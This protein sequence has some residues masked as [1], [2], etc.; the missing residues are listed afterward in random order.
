MTPTVRLLTT[1]LAA[2]A[3]VSGCGPAAAHGN[4]TMEQ[5][6]CVLRLGRKAIHFA[7]YQPQTAQ[8]TEFCEDIPSLGKTVVVLDFINNELRDIPVEVRVVSAEGSEN[9]L[10]REPVLLVPFNKYLTGTVS[11]VQEFNEPGDF[12]G[13]VTA[14]KDRMDVA[15]FPFSVGRPR[16]SIWHYL[17]LGVA[18]IG[19][20]FGFFLL[21]MK[22]RDRILA[23]TRV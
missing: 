17:G 10:D 5:D 20:I 11:F 18:V 14:G 13:L 23:G 4:L 22:R 8:T 21:G 2:E 12:V 19:A 15:R 7:G 16:F 9:E 3:L 1:M 6:E